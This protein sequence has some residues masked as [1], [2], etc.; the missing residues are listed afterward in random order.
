MFFHVVSCRVYVW[1]AWCIEIHCFE[2]GKTPQVSLRSR[3]WRGLSKVRC[4][5]SGWGFV[6]GLR[7]GTDLRG[8]RGTSGEV[9]GNFWGSLG[10]FRG[11]SGLLLNSTV[12][13]LPGKS[14]KN[15]W[16]SLGNF[17]GSPGT[18]QK[19]GKPDSLPA[20]RQICLQFS[21]V[22]SNTRSL[23][24]KA[25]ALPPFLVCFL[26]VPVHPTPPQ[27]ILIPQIPSSWDLTTTLPSRGKATCKGRAGSWGGALGAQN[28]SDFKSN[29]L[30]I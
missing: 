20:T 23:E 7:K 25:I 17:R 22:L 15:F 6:S 28:A 18:F 29:P 2:N 24:K 4:F 1:D 9:W 10:N 13:E 27:A 8:S 16:G 26:F 5:M 3:P 11:T 21:R 19:L 14:P 30:A 12:R